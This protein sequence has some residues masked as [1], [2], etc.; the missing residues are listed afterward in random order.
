MLAP[1]L[2]TTIEHDRQVDKFIFPHELQAGTMLFDVPFTFLMGGWNLGKSSFL[3]IWLTW[4]MEQHP[5]EN[6]ILMAPTFDQLRDVIVPLLVD[7][8]DGTYYEGI[9]KR[10]D[11]QYITPYG[12]IFLLSAQDPEH[13][14]GRKVC[15]VGGDEAGQW[16]YEAWF[17]VK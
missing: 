16:Y 2:Y 3:P 5:N 17:H 10:N 9:W 6:S 7:T 8:V 14:Q 1:T 12:T 11:H 15:D 4:M 13:I